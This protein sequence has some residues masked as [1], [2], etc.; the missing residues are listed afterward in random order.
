MRGAQS[1]ENDII[2][3]HAGDVINIQHDHVFCLS[4]TGSLSGMNGLLRR[5]Y[6]RLPPFLKLRAETESLRGR[7]TYLQREDESYY[8]GSAH[9]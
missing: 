5:F 1:G 9:V 7:L 8:P 3:R 6:V 2:M 4:F